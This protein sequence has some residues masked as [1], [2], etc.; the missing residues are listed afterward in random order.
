MKVKTAK[1][2]A[3]EVVE[4]QLKTN[5]D[6]FHRTTPEVLKNQIEA[7]LIKKLNEEKYVLWNKATK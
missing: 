4:E 7:H 6:I 5:T 3:Q 1:E 2:A